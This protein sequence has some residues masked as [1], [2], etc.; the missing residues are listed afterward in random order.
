[1]MAIRGGLGRISLS[2]S[3]RIVLAADLVS[4]IGTGLVVAFT[5][6]YVARVHHHG[7]SA[8][9]LAVA[10]LAAGSVPSNAVAGRIVDRYGAVTVVVYGW[11]LAAA[12]DA[13]M[14]MTS[15]EAGLTISC[16]VVGVGAGAAYPAMNALLGELTAGEVRR[17]VFGV[18]HGLLNAGFS[19]G[20]LAA[21]GIVSSGGVGRYK[22]LY[23]IDAITFGVAAG[24]LTTAKPGI[25]RPT[26]VA[27][28][29][30]AERTGSYRAVLS[31]CS[32]RRL[33]AIS[34]LLV[35]FGFSQFHAALPLVLSRPGGLHPGAVAVIFAANT[36]TV[37][38]AAY[39]VAAATKHVGRT[40]LIA[41]G[42]IC[43][44]LGWLLLLASAR[45]GHD[46][47]AAGLAIATAVVIGLGETVLSPSLGPSVNEL[48]TDALR[49]RYNAVDSMVFSFGS[50]SG[51]ILAGLLVSGSGSW[52][53]LTILAAG[54]LFA[55]AVAAA[56]TTPSR[57]RT[58][59]ER[60]IPACL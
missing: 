29:D 1:M 4:N 32:F 6:I 22:V 48:A 23:A 14:A 56:R 7:P 42:A 5:A 40:T 12:G 38:L 36:T 19:L 45:M 41:M 16:A 31:D 50:V 55:A 8:G 11:L 54:C 51:P 59:V 60:T 49:G 39:P 27:R 33:C 24:L 44:A 34:A 47:A 53:L 18:R 13:G 3:T 57:S 20:A 10:A 2:R 28:R 52:G 15:S 37:A 26:L 46:T 17:V 35:T 9:A 43:F 30:T 25:A 58:N 21:A